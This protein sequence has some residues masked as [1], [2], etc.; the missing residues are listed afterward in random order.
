MRSNRQPWESSDLATKRNYGLN[1]RMHVRS[2][3]ETEL[4][5]KSVG[6]VLSAALLSHLD[7]PRAHAEIQR[8]LRPDG[9]F[10]MKVCPH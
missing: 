3:Y 1:A 5:R 2:A 7:L 10:L 6:L 4:Q 9:L 8:I